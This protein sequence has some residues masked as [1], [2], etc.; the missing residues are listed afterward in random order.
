MTSA[1]RSL[2]KNSISN[3]T[4]EELPVNPFTTKPHDM[5]ESIAAVFGKTSDAIHRRRESETN[6]LQ[7]MAG[8]SIADYVTV[9]KNL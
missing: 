3:E 5:L 6:T 7:F 9:H 1:V 4:L 2:I 8:Q